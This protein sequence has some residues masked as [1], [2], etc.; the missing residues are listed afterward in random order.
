VGPG[1]FAH[2]I[3]E[4]NVAATLSLQEAAQFE[5]G[6]VHNYWVQLLAV[7]GIVGFSTVL[8]VWVSVVEGIRNVWRTGGRDR[9]LATIGLLLVAVLAGDAF[10]GIGV[11]HPY[12]WTFLALVYAHVRTLDESATA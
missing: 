11:I 9:E 10:W 3:A 4:S 6:R 1:Q 8:A 12:R 7:G 2:W 5:I